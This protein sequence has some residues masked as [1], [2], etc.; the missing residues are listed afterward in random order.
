[1]LKK[2]RNAG[3]QYVSIKMGKVMLVD[4]SRCFE[5]VGQLNVEEVFQNS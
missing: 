2:R 3:K 1:M 5:K 4:K